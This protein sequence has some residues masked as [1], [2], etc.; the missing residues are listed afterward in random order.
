MRK[1]LFPLKKTAENK[2]LNL[3]F[4]HTFW[5][6]YLGKSTSEINTATLNGFRINISKKESNRTFPV[7][8]GVKCSILLQV[9]TGKC[10]Y[11]G[12]ADEIPMVAHMNRLIQP[13]PEPRFQSPWQR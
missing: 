6:Q 4:S 12:H 9:W 10:L 5:A 2:E 11:C 1:R 7:Q 3:N 13:T 8:S